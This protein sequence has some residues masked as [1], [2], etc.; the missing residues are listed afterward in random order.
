MVSSMRQVMVG[1]RVEA[2]AACDGEIA[3]RDHQLGI[4]FARR[5]RRQFA[6]KD[7]AGQLFAKEL[8]VR[9]VLVERVDDV[10]AV[11]PGIRHRE[12]GRLAGGVGIA[13]T[14]SQCR[15]QRSP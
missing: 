2:E 6:G 7:V 8:V 4:V 15:P 1:D 5:L 3:G 13:H 12:V 9:L 10:V 11:A 14:S